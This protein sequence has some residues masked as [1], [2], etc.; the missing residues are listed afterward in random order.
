MIDSNQVVIT[1][2]GLV[3]PVGLTT[4]NSWDALLAGKSGVSALHN[5]PSWFPSRVAGIVQGEESL[6]SQALTS[7]KLRKIDRFTQL[8]FLAA[9]EALSNAQCSIIFPENRERFGIYLGVGIGGLTTITEGVRLY[10][11]SGIKAISPFLLTR[12]IANEAPGWI[13]MELN[14]QGPMMAFSN[15]CASG[16]DAIGFAYNAIKSGSADYMLAGGTESCINELS[17]ASFG[18]MRALS[19]WKGNPENA[20][21]PFSRDRCGFVIAEGACVLMLERKEHAQK[22]GA[23]IVA[24]IVSYAATSDAYHIA[25]IHPEGRGIIQ[26]LQKSLIHAQINPDDIGYINAHGTATPMNDATETKAL[27]TIFKDSLDANKP[28]HIIVSSTKSMTGH[29]LGATGAVEIACTALALQHQIAPPTINLFENDPECDL[30]YAPHHAKPI[31]TNYA[32]S[33][34]F[35]FGGGNAVV[36][37]KRV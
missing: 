29:M 17:L 9:L 26:A 32:L 28:N 15:A 1:G 21:R 16:A 8:A 33:N 12:V 10:D 3:T 4:K 22:R 6:L 35:G 14:L 5:Y 30:D 25:A 27:K 36:V 37:L 13:S 23:P 11:A 31:T 19:T 7:A 2:I 20:S 24:E 18:N 34:S